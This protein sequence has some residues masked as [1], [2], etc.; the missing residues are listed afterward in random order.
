[1]SKIQAIRVED[2]VIELIPHGIDR[3]GRLFEIDSVS[4]LLGTNGAGKTRMLS[5]LANAVGS[6]EDDSVQFYF[7]GTPN[8]NYEPRAP[9]K[10]ICA[11]YYSA[12][13][14]KRKIVRKKGVINAS[15]SYKKHD[16]SRR[17]EQLGEVAGILEVDTRLL[18][19]FGYSRV[20][21]RSVLIPVLKRFGEKL[22]SELKYTIFDLDNMIRKS[23]STEVDDYR[24]LDKKR[25]SIL[26]R[27][28]GLLEDEIDAQLG[29]ANRCLFLA[30]LE[31]MHTKDKSYDEKLAAIAF[32]NHVGLILT[33]LDI[34]SFEKLQSIVKNT[35]FVLTNYASKKRFDWNQ[36]VHR[37]Q[38][39]SFD[40]SEMVRHHE[41]SIR[42]EW[43]NLSS[44]LQALVEQFSL[45][46]EAIG[47]AVAQARFSILLLIDEGDAYLHLDWQRRYF[48]MLNKFL[49]GL[50]RKY[51]LQNLQLIM[52]TH[53]PLL[54][55]DIPGKLVTSLDSKSSINSFAAPLEEVVAG[56]FGSNSLGEFAAEKIN[57][58]Y[59]RSQAG[60][61][62]SEDYNVVDIIGDV[63]IKSALKRSF[64]K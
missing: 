33:P 43:S 44:G 51:G 9:Y 30:A 11:I 21:F 36:R 18:G 15:P 25:E 58:I 49:G 32:L 10:D 45:I 47:K 2:R 38:I 48:S 60:K 26:K 31:Y 59:K 20:V 23:D 14:Y 46:D 19:V 64:Q 52:A 4:L 13:P 24:A 57:D 42:I 12:L 54:A 22:S 40:Q 62:T 1:M 6:S 37:F 55:A 17:M 53:S 56:A 16:E 34:P 3:L 61:A 8:G 63:A 29:K 7:K 39:D 27:L 50:K 41:T 5:S 35:N 28:E